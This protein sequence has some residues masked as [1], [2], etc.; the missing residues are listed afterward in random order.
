LVESYDGDD[1]PEEQ[2]QDLFNQIQRALQ[3]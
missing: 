2:D 1:D 3:G